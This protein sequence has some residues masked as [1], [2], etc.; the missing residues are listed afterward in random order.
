MVSMVECKYC[1]LRYEHAGPYGV[2]AACIECVRENLLFTGAKAPRVASITA[3]EKEVFAM[4]VPPE[5]NVAQVIRGKGDDPATGELMYD[6]V[7]VLAQKESVEKLL[8]SG[9]GPVKEMAVA[10]DHT[11]SKFVW[12]GCEEKGF[13]PGASMMDALKDGILNKVKKF[14]MA[15]DGPWLYDIE[16]NEKYAA[17]LQRKLLNEMVGSSSSSGAR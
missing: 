8:E 3:G 6:E 5:A 15:E 12:E 2:E 11:Q 17:E 10:Y 14:K 1:G 9:A 16:P 13:D 4:Q 7:L